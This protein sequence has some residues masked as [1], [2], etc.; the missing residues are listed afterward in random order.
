MS[1]KSKSEE[2]GAARSRKTQRRKAASRGKAISLPVIRPDTAGIDIG[3]MEIFVAV[4]P[5]RD[6][7]PVRSFGTFT[8]DLNQLAGWLRECGVTSVAMEST[9]VYWIPLYEM[10]A[11]QGI[12]VCLVNA[13]HF[14]NVPG[15]KTDAL[16][17]L[18]VAA[19]SA[20]GGLIARIVPA[21]AGDL[22][23]TDAAPAPAGPGGD[24]LRACAAYAEVD[25]TD[26]PEAA[27]CDQRVDRSDRTSDHRRDSGRRTGSQDPG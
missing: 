20:R 27:T 1:K 4:S 14:K 6:A 9:G 25:G 7:E 8:D 24:D 2:A 12:E 23:H 13:R 22:R 18:S 17:G 5:D 21:R 15:G 10:L 16:L 19:V 26:E 11:E 3:S